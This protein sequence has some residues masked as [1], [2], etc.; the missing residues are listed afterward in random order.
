VWARR[1]GPEEVQQGTGVSCSDHGSLPILWSVGLSHQAHMASHQQSLHREICMPRQAQQQK[2]GQQQ[3]TAGVPPPV[4]GEKV[5]FAHRRVSDYV[6]LEEVIFSSLV[7]WS[8]H[9]HT[10][11]RGRKE[12]LVVVEA[13]FAV[14]ISHNTTWHRQV[15]EA[16]EK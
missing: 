6:D 1:S 14:M 2:K 9:F 15:E 10:T 3:P 5:G 7:L 16:S 8:R 13:C 11:E 4:A 12:S